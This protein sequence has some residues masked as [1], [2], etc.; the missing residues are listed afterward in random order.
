MFQPRSSQAVAP[1]LKMMTM[2]GF[3]LFGATFLFL[4]LLVNNPYM[5]MELKNPIAIFE[6]NPTV[7]MFLIYA[8][9]A[10][11]LSIAI[12][13]V[14]SKVGLGKI[15]EG[16]ESAQISKQNLDDSLLP[17]VLKALYTPYIL[18]LALAESV[19]LFGFLSANMTQEISSALPFFLFAWLVMSQTLAT[20]ARV[21]KWYL[22]GQ[23]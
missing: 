7:K 14:F 19:A 8:V 15:F 16:T 6:D 2:L 23:M 12:P 18:R 21:E 22:K 11:V 5:N 4:F 10:G 20:R 13:R 9:G 1:N 3:M 17:Q